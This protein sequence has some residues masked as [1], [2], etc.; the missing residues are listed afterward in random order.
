M[1]FSPHA[2]GISCNNYRNMKTY[3]FQ[4][5]LF[6]HILDIFICFQYE[7]PESFQ[8]QTYKFSMNYLD[9]FEDSTNVFTD[10]VFEKIDTFELYIQIES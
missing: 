1:Y 10:K 6:L 4:W 8:N 9:R 2:S 5:S 3:L 7:G